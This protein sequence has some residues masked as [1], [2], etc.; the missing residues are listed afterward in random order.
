MTIAKHAKQRSISSALASNSKEWPVNSTK[1]HQGREIL[2]AAYRK[3]KTSLSHYFSRRGSPSTSNSALGNWMIAISISSR[4]YTKIRSAN[5]WREK[6][7]RSSGTGLKCSETNPA[8]VSS[9]PSSMITGIPSNH[10]WRKS[11]TSKKTY[12]RLSRQKRS[13]KRR[14]RTLS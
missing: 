2:S 5:F 1:G 6:K 3:L 13:S 4:R 10:F 11:R 8:I 12:F 7:P 14:T 9:P